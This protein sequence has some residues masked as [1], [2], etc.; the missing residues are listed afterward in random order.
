[1]I[2]RRHLLRSM[3]HR[4]ATIRKVFRYGTEQTPA[5]GN[6]AHLMNYSSH[7][8]DRLR[9]AGAPAKP[10]WGCAAA[11]RSPR[12]I[13]SLIANSFCETTRHLHCARPRATSRPREYRER[14]VVP[15]R[16]HGAPPLGA[17]SIRLRL[18]LAHNDSS[19]FVG[20]PYANRPAA[21]VRLKLIPG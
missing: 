6:D 17:R 3:S 8:I 9:S 1:M 18:R 13:P 11:G 10:P 5:A 20:F 21:F 4:V 2:D 12:Q 14:C 19:S 7:S 15:N 16:G